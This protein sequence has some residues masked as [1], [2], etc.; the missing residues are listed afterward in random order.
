MSNIYYFQ[1]YITFYVDFKKIYAHDD[2]DFC[3]I[4]KFGHEIIY[5]QTEKPIK[6]ISIKRIQSIKD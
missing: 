6:I 1:L 4:F 5:D 2:H 3:S